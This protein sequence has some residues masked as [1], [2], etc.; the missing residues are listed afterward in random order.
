MYSH[1]PLNEYVT[2]SHER[3]VTV[4][5]ETDKYYH[6]NTPRVVITPQTQETSIRR[7]LLQIPTFHHNGIYSFMLSKFLLRP[8]I[9]SRSRTHHDTR[10]VTHAN[11]KRETSPDKE[12]RTKTR[13]HAEND[14][15]DA[16]P[17]KQKKSKFC[18]QVE[19]AGAEAAPQKQEKTKHRAQT[20]DNEVEEV[21]EVEA[22]PP[23]QIR[24]RNRV[25]AEIAEP[26]P[27][28]PTQKRDKHRVQAEIAEH[29]P[30]PPKQRRT[31]ILAQAEPSP[32]KGER[33]RHAP[34]LA[35]GMINFEH[36]N[37]KYTYNV[38][39]VENAT[40]SD[41]VDDADDAD[42]ADDSAAPSRSKPVTAVTNTPAKT[43]DKNNSLTP[44]PMFPG[45]EN[46]TAEKSKQARKD[47]QTTEEIETEVTKRTAK[48]ADR[49]AKVLKKHQELW[50]ES[51]AAVYE[52]LGFAAYVGDEEDER[53]ARAKFDWV[54]KRKIKGE[55]YDWPVA[56]RVKEGGACD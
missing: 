6:S 53:E 27:A 3:F 45:L 29:E 44:G 41:A 10:A 40:Q 43:N 35:N 42:D 54:R 21:E 7:A 23:K 38:P 12:K 33:I 4:F 14:K 55:R 49:L 2:V 17:Q 16:P 48:M 22:A 51:Q 18:A 11:K 50:L 26:E 25:H 36:P 37:T 13:A 15:S 34:K 32:R 1:P 24:E 47:E 20:E 5:F 46:R 56:K 52:F 9:M 31:R 30:A 28:P 8:V 19:N 39:P